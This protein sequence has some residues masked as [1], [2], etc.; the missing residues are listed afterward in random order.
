VA[1]IL[2]TLR[3]ANRIVALTHG[4]GTVAL[5]LARALTAAGMAE[6]RLGRRNRAVGGV[7]RPASIGPDRRVVWHASDRASRRAPESTVD[8]RAMMAGW[9]PY[10]ARLPGTNLGEA[11]GVLANALYKCR[12]PCAASLAVGPPHSRV[13]AA[14]V[15]TTRAYAVGEGVIADL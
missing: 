3:Q 11:C 1:L 9:T 13:A 5:D 10:C 4:R 7:R 15:P 14:N 8:W 12:D 6:A 2:P